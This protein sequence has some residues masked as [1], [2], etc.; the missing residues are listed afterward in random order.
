MTVKITITLDEERDADVISFLRSLS[1]AERNSEILSIFRAYIN[2]AEGKSKS[3]IIL[4]TLQDLGTKIDG[5]KEFV[6]SSP[7]GDIKKV[8]TSGGNRSY[9]IDIEVENNLMGLGR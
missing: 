9:E 2:H 5:L 8:K 1:N 4:E 7:T 3:D 6:A